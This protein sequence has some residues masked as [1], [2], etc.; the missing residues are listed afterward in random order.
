[1]K[2]VATIRPPKTSLK[3]VKVYWMC[4]MWLHPVATNNGRSLLRICE[5]VLKIVLSFLKVKEA[6]HYFDLGKFIVSHHDHISHSVRNLSR[7][8][9]LWSTCQALLYLDIIHETCQQYMHMNDLL[10][11]NP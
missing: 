1:M 9:W 2:E 10:N 7:L 4:D 6:S 11:T 3:K 5:I 8:I